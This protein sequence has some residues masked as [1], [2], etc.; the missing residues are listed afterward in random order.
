M[1]KHSAPDPIPGELRKSLVFDTSS[2]LEA[3]QTAI[4]W[5]VAKAVAVAIPLRIP[6]TS[7]SRDFCGT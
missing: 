1:L 2:A 6:G 4:D 7:Q 3:R 5:G